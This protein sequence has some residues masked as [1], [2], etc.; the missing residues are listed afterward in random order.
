MK[1]IR[2]MLIASTLLAAYCVVLFA[3][4]FPWM[5]VVLGIGVLIALCNKKRVHLHAMGT[6][7]WV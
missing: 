6:A 1:L 7:R 3:V 4:L 2:W 5:W